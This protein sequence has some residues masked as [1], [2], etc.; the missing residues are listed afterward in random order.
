MANRGLGQKK[1]NDLWAHF[2]YNEAEKKTQCIAL[3][4]EG[5]QCGHKS[6]GKNTTNLKRHIKT[7]HKAIEVS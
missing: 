6:A 7:H 5:K 4:S 3:D 2:V 1:R